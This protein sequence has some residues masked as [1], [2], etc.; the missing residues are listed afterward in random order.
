MFNGDGEK[1]TMLALRRASYPVPKSQEGC[2]RS[3]VW[4]GSAGH[5]ICRGPRGG[6]LVGAVGRSIILKLVLH[7]TAKVSELV[8]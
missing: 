7:C 6:S 4:L 3:Q 8:R 2:V 1:T 5:H